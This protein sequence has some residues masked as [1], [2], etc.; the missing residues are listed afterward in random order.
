[1][2][3]SAH[4]WRGLAAVAIGLALALAALVAPNRIEW[5]AWPDACAAEARTRAEALAT[6][7]RSDRAI[8]VLLRADRRSPDAATSLA[9]ARL[10]AARGERASARRYA[11]EAHERAPGDAETATLAASLLEDVDPGRAA[12]IAEAV[13]ARE[14][15]RVDARILH[16]R[17]AQ[18]AGD[19][20]RALAEARAIAGP[21][22]T[23]PAAWR[24]LGG[25]I[26][27]QIDDA[28]ATGL[29]PADALFEEGI[30][31]LSRAAALDREDWVASLDRAWLLSMW[32][33]H[34]E[35]ARDAAWRACRAAFATLPAEE[36]EGRA[37]RAM[38]S[39]ARRLGDPELIRV[40]EGAAAG[41]VLP[42]RGPHGS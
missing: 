17:I 14:P 26:K 11:L 36:L 37:R 5:C 25:L 20:E 1:V 34:E 29:V 27:Q 39:L 22:Q 6:E 12:R 4:A 30:D 7:G 15:E 2:H 24:H 23:D 41:A 3:G 32:P 16:S 38:L 42:R 40:T 33:G 18:T 19:R 13:I 28:L 8:E 35:E 21:Q 10:H 31:A 9:L